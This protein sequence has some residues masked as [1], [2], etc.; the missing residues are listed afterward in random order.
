MPKVKQ[1][2]GDSATKAIGGVKPSDVDVPKVKGTANPSPSQ[3]E[4]RAIIDQKLKEYG[5][6]W[7]EFNRLRNTHVTK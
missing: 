7:D 6:S 4:T 1:V 5:V 2:S 3:S